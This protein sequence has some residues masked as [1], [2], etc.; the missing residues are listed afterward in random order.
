MTGTEA[1]PRRDHRPPEVPGGLPVLGHVAELLRRPTT[2][3]ERAS[4]V[5]DVVSI[6]LG[7]RRAVLVNSPELMMQVLHSDVGHWA[8]GLAYEKARPMIG[9]GIVGLSGA[10]HRKQRRLIQPAFRTAKI[11]QYSLIMRDVARTHMTRWREGETIDAWKE[12]NSIALEIVAKALFSADMSASAVRD[13]QA[14][15]PVV[16]RGIQRRFVMPPAVQ[17]IPTPEGRRYARALELLH[18]TIAR[19][20]SR[21]VNA[22]IAQDD[23][24]SALLS[25]VDP[26]TGESMSAQQVHDEVVTLLS[27]GSE[28]VATALS[29]AAFELGRRPDVQQKLQNEVQSVLCGRA[30]RLADIANLPYTEMVLNE[31]MRMYPPLF[32]ATRCPRMNTV[33]GGYEVEEGSMIILSF[34]GLHHN[35]RVYSSPQTFDP[36]RWR[37]TPADTLPRGAFIPFSV[38]PSSCI[39]SGF[40]RAEAVIVLATLAQHWTLGTQ[41]SD[42][43]T[44]LARTV[45]TPDRLRIRLQP[46]A[47]DASKG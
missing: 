23:V 19:I 46:A 38:G 42:S 29:W 40:A 25:A 4:E 15:L 2:F 33:L 1:A 26:E 16:L 28:T 35:P 10:E 34:H 36:E 5:G 44:P 14:S 11:E 37:S 17:K 18:S 45:L 20:I 30:P 31:A 43:V 32:L 21:R 47:C 39:G 27:A 41:D 12:F 24:L 13:V 9:N 7:P 3:L 22:D 6:R 8:K